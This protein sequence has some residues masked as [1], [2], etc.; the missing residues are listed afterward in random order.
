MD[1]IG[2]PVSGVGFSSYTGQLRP[3]T[4]LVLQAKAECLVDTV[5]MI[6]QRVMCAHVCTCI[7][8]LGSTFGWTSRELV[9]QLQLLVAVHFVHLELPSRSQVRTLITARSACLSALYRLCLTRLSHCRRSV[10]LVGLESVRSNRDDAT[11]APRL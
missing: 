8:G 6:F 3:Y 9:V 7:D 10:S 1:E 5:I 4:C 2:N 11:T